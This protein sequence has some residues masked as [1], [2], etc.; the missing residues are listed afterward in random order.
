MKTIQKIFLFLIGI[1]ITINT[2]RL[3]AQAPYPTFDDAEKDGWTLVW[4]DEF[5]GTQIDRSK[6]IY[7]TGGTINNEAQL[8]TAQ[9]ENAR[10]ENGNL[11]IEAHKKK[12]TA[13]DGRTSDYT[14]ACLTTCTMQNGKWNSLFAIKYG[15]IEIRAK[16]PAGR[17]VWPALWL[18]EL[19]AEPKDSWQ[20]C[21]EIDIMEYVGHCP[22]AVHANFHN[23]D[24][25]A[26]YKRHSFGNYLVK[27]TPY[28]GFHTYWM[29]WSP[30]LIEIFYDTKKI[31]SYRPDPEKP[32]RFPYNKPYYL[33]MNLAV[34]GSWGGEKGI[35][36]S[37]F[38]CRYEIDFVRIYQKNKLTAARIDPL[39][40]VTKTQADCYQ[41]S[42][43]AEVAKG[44]TASFQFVLR[45]EKPIENLKIEAGNLQ[46][47]IVQQ[48][49]N[50]RHGLENL[51]LEKVESAESNEMIK[52]IKPAAINFVGYVKAERNGK[53]TEYPDV[54]LDPQNE[55][56]AKT[57]QPL[58]I[59]YKIPK[60]TAAG[61]YEA[62]IIISGKTDGKDFR[63]EKSVTARVFNVTV[64]E[65]TL[66]VTNWFFDSFLDK[67]N[68]N[69][70]A[71]QFSLRYWELLKLIA[72]TMR[73]HGQNVYLISPTRNCN[74]TLNDSKYSFDFTNFD[75]AVELFIN[76]GGLKRIEGGHL[77]GWPHGTKEILINV[78]DGSGKFN[79]FPLSDEKTKNFLSQFIPA[80][81][82]HL[83]DKKWEQ[84][85][86]QHIGDEPTSIE[87]YNEVAKYLK[88]LEPNLKTIEATILGK[89][90][91]DNIDVHVPIIWY[92]DQDKD[93]YKEHQKNGGEVWFYISC[94][95]RDYANRFYDRSLLQ[96]RLLH[97]FN[98]RYNITGYLHWGLNHWDALAG[99]DKT[100]FVDKHKTLPAGDCFIIYPSYEKVYSSLRFAS[101]R[102]A[103]CDYELLKLL[104]NRDPSKAKQLAESLIP[105]P[106]KYE[107]NINI[108][109]AK[110]V[111]L[112]QWL[113]E[114]KQK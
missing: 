37:I 25:H 101:M 46:Q 72:N 86:V 57:N 6:W 17:G 28:D 33:L 83:C 27:E 76:E 19:P 85:Y 98:F 14:S 2:A 43:S 69:K 47:V 94:D 5:D 15:R 50:L 84:I 30:D 18:L 87:P 103:V 112:L 90:V 16:L 9:N 42:S 66:W 24:E 65:Q 1:V 109:R 23:W 58:L 52:M 79:P 60:E 40:K 62:T 51:K 11:V 36:D 106:N 44:E 95:S 45:G 88:S 80:L 108:F 61:I 99:D 26:E 49:K 22:D 96:N 56:V 100:G 114:S 82:K 48:S 75:K 68:E 55:I 77:A 32:E 74:I 107:N 67:L 59:S 110:R 105:Q 12:Y 89:K 53:V 21:G 35:D 20:R 97:W 104:E 34:G 102:D 113:S 91:G 93:F 39:D 111:Q 64:P 7:E 63:C 41:I 31:V 92:Y 4:G 71:E 54:L 81:Y 29:E 78:P 8:Y 38:P 13:P 70:K 73:E 10:L 3:F